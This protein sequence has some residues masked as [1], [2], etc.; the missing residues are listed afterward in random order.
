MPVGS[1][2]GEEDLPYLRAELG[3]GFEQV[4]EYISSLLGE[5]QGGE[6][7]ASAETVS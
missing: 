7:K 4:Q 6:R 1:A 3:E 2:R 5:A